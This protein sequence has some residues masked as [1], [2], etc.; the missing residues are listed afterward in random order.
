MKPKLP[1]ERWPL[2]LVRWLDSSVPRGWQNLADWPGV[3]SLECVSV[4]FLFAEDKLSKTIIPPFAYPED[5]VNRLGSGVLI[6]PAGCIVSIEK[7]S[8][9]SACSAK[10]AGL[11]LRAAL[12]PSDSARARSSRR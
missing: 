12:A 4:G 3:S 9:T 8:V 2:V 6:I 1:K 5:E 11:V 10:G 7:L